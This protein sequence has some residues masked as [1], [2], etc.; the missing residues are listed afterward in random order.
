MLLR[1]PARPSGA[2]WGEEVSQWAQQFMPQDSDF[3]FQPTE[4]RRLSQQDPQWGRGREQEAIHQ[5]E[6]AFQ[7]PPPGSL[8]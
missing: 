1:A 7:S 3:P 4:P 5:T 6:L 8:F 2:G